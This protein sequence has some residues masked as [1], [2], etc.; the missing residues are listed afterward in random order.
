MKSLKK[1]QLTCKAFDDHWVARG[2]LSWHSQEVKIPMAPPESK[3]VNWKG[4]SYLTEVLRKLVVHLLK[5]KWHV[6]QREDLYDGNKG[7]IVIYALILTT[8][9]ALFLHNHVNE[10]SF[11]AMLLMNLIDLLQ[12]LHGHVKCHSSQKNIWKH[13]KC[14]SCGKISKLPTSAK[15]S[16][17]Y[18]ANWIEYIDEKCLRITMSTLTNLTCLSTP[19]KSTPSIEWELLHANELSFSQGLVP[20]IKVKSTNSKQDILI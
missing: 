15:W 10:S 16:M 20:F 4:F 1:F 19:A 11:W 5:I 9:K 2:N 7:M 13:G 8:E 12:T 3:I 18:N 6:W 17:T 14:L